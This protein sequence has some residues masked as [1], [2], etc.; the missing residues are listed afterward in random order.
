MHWPVGVTTTVPSSF[1]G[2]GEDAGG[3]LRSW[4]AALV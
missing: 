3:G 1:G 4:F 2:F